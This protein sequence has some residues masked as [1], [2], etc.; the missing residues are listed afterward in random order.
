MAC[1]NAGTPHSNGSQFFITLD[2][3]E[4]LDKKNTIFGK[5]MCLDRELLAVHVFVQSVVSSELSWLATCCLQ[6][7]G[8]SIFNLL[9]LADIE[10]DK[11]DRPVYPQKILSVEVAFF[12]TIIF[13]SYFKLW[14]HYGCSHILFG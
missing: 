7:T 5:V 8:D 10:T 4:W 3:C 14:E 9:S 12:S 13:C 11:D 1:A 6:V 2:R